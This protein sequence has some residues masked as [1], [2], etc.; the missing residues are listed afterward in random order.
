MSY[1]RSTC[2]IPRVRTPHIK[3]KGL[4]AHGLGSMIRLAQRNQQP[5][6]LG[7]LPVMLW[8]ALM[9]REDPDA[10]RREA[11]KL[12]VDTLEASARWEGLA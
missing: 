7:P 3:I 2:G 9:M 10:G 11:K 6:G 1:D 12:G 5:A 4:A 8:V